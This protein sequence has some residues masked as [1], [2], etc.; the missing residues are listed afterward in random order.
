MNLALATPAVLLLLPLALLGAHEK[1][2]RLMGLALVVLPAWYMLGPAFGLY[3]LGAVVP[4]LH[5][6]RAPANGWFV[7]GF[8]LAAM[9]ALGVVAAERR[10]R[11]PWLGMGLA[12]FFIFDLCLVNSW[13]NPLTYGVA[14]LRHYLQNGISSNAVLPSPAVCWLVSLAFAVLMLAAAWRIAATRSTGDLL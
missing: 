9:A 3:H 2:G 13:I 11:K 4:Y 12:A 7:A 10:W 8:G 6:M 1:R 14:G 5:K